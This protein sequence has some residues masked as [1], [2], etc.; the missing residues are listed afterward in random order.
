M[1]YCILYNFIS[2][3]SEKNV[4][5]IA[6]YTITITEDIIKNF[7]IKC[8]WVKEY[9]SFFV[10]WFK[11]L[12][13]LIQHRHVI[14]SFLIFI[15]FLL[16]FVLHRVKDFIRFINSETYNVYFY[17][18]FVTLIKNIH[19]NSDSWKYYLWFL[20]SFDLLF[21]TEKLSFLCNT[22]FHWLIKIFL[23]SFILFSSIDQ[24]LF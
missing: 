14:L 9:L 21:L 7:I 23:V 12:S 19:K 20:D 13:D 8:S 22:Y 10:N 4:W 11:D 17:L 16:S 1:F 2:H 18:L 3:S 5:F 6:E 24:L 15:S